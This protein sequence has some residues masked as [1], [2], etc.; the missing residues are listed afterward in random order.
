M[1][2]KEDY[3][4]DVVSMDYDS[5]KQDLIDNENSQALEKLDKLSVKELDDIM[6]KVD[7]MFSNTR[8]E[9]WRDFL[10]QVCKKIKEEKWVKILQNI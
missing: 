6:W 7:E 9:L 1:S 2:E 8:A 3:R 5:I 4:F 10:F